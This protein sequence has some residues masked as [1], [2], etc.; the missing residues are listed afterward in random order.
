MLKKDDLHDRTWQLVVNRD[1]SHDT[2]G[3]PVVKRDT[4]HELKHGPVEYTAIGLRFTG[5]GAINL[6]EELRHAETNP[7][8]K[9]HEGYC[10]S[11]KNSRPKSF[12]R[13]DLPR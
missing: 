3:Q 7:L 5:Y 2:S 11:H 1:E 9:I 13:N 12:A 10:A 6:T 4:H 8:C